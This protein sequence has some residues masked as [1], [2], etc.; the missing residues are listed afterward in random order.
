M[1]HYVTL[2]YVAVEHVSVGTV[3]EALHLSNV[4]SL[5][6]EDEVPVSQLRSSIDELYTL[7]RLH[8][9]V[10]DSA[11]LNQAKELCSNWLQMNYHH[12]SGEKIDAGFLKITLCLLCGSKVADKAR[13]KF[14]GGLSPLY[15]DLCCF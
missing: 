10:T 7:L 6:R 9:P 12:S 15:D 13:C 11:R 2:C 4:W 3:Q 5:Q 1:L 14:K 8:R